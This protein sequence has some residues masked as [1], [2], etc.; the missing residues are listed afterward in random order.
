MRGSGMGGGGGVGISSNDL[1]H[2]FAKGVGSK[3]YFVH[4]QFEY[5]KFEFI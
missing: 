2:F 3:A 1:Y 5:K 4:L